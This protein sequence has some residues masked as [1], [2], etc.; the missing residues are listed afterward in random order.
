M[1]TCQSIWRRSKDKASSFEATKVRPCW[2]HVGNARKIYSCYKNISSSKAR[3]TAHWK[4]RIYA[5]FIYQVLRSSSSDVSVTRIIMFLEQREKTA[6]AACVVLYS[7]AADI[8]P[9]LAGIKLTAP[10]RCRIDR[11]L[12]PR[13]FD[14]R[15]CEVPSVVFGLLARKGNVANIGKRMDIFRHIKG[16]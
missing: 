12:S 9:A 13:S 8:T 15:C 14:R 16:Q 7:F 2:V 4:L 10:K 11:L 5:Q 1:S 6:G 3:E